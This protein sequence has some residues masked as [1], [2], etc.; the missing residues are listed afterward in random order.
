MLLLCLVRTFKKIIHYHYLM[1]ERLFIYLL[2][3]FRATPM[4]YVSSQTRGRIR[5]A[6]ASKSHSTPDPKCI[7][8]LYRS[9]RQHQILNPL[10]EDRDGTGILRDT[11]W[12]F[13]C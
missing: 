13:Y 2:C 3:F 5:A 6:A 9:S 1:K 11:S 4:T 8:N 7:C 12:V 10:S